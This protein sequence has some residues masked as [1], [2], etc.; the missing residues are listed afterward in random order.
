MIRQLHETT[1]APSDTFVPVSFGGEHHGDD[2]H[3]AGV[4]DVAVPLIASPGV[5][6][7]VNTA[8]N[9]DMVLD[10]F[11][12]TDPP[13]DLETT[14]IT[15]DPNGTNYTQ[16]PNHQDEWSA[17]SPDG[18]WVAWAA[19]PGDDFTRIRVG[20]IDD[21][22]SAVEPDVIG[23]SIEFESQSQPAWR[24]DGSALA[25]VSNGDLW[26]VEIDTSGESPTFDNMRLVYDYDDIDNTGLFVGHPTY[27]PDQHPDPEV[28]SYEIAFDANGDI[29]KIASDGTTGDEEQL[30]STG[31]A[32]NPSWS[33]TPGDDRIA[34]QRDAPSIILGPSAVLTSYVPPQPAG[35]ISPTVHGGVHFTVT[36]TADENDAQACL[37]EAG[38]SLREA[39]T[40]ANTAPNDTAPDQIDFS[41]SPAGPITIQPTSALGPLPAIIDPVIL[42]GFSQPGVFVNTEPPHVEIDGTSAGASANGLE[43]SA[44]SSLIQGFV[45]NRFGGAGIRLTGGG[46]NVVQ[47]NYIGTD[48]LGTSDLGNGTGIEIFN[49]AAN[50]VGGA[51]LIPDTLN[52]G[53]LNVVSGNVAGIYVGLGML[54][55]GNRIIGNYIGLDASGAGALGNSGAGIGISGPSNIIGSATAG[56]RNIISANGTGIHIGVN[57]E[58]SANDNVV[59][60]NY[61]GTDVSGTLD[62]G[63]TSAGVLVAGFSGQLIGGSG[64]GEGNLISG[65]N[66]LGVSIESGATITTVEGNRIG[67]SAAGDSAIANGTGLRILAANGNTV[68]GA[69]DAARN[70]ISGNAA[71]GVDLFA[72]NGNTISHN[73][74]GTD[75]TGTLALPNG[76]GVTILGTTGNDTTNNTISGNVVS[77]NTGDGIQISGLAATGQTIFDNRIGINSDG[78]SLGN[79]GRGVALISGAQSNM[80]GGIDPGEPN[81]IAF[82]GSDGVLVLDGPFNRVRGNSIHSNGT[83]P[84][85]DPPD[86]DLGIDLGGDGVTPNDELDRDSSSEDGIG[87][88]G[89]NFPIILSASQSGGSITVSG[90][91]DSEDFL[92][93]PTIDVYANDSCNPSGNGEGERY[94]GSTDIVPGLDSFGHGTWS[95][96]VA[97]SELGSEVTATA[98][99]N[100]QNTSEF[101]PCQFVTA[102]SATFTVNQV[103]DETD[104]DGC[105]V[106]HCTLREAIEG[107]NATP[108]GD[109]IN[110]D[111]PDTVDTPPHVITLLTALPDITDPVDIDGTTE[112]DYAGLPVIELDGSALDGAGDHGLHITADTI[113][114]IGLA[115]GGFGGA[116]IFIDGDGSNV[117]DNNV[118]QRNHIGVDATGTSPRGN[119]GDGIRIVESSGNDIGGTSEGGGNVIAGN[120]GNGVLVDPGGGSATDS[121][122]N[123]IAGNLIGID[124]GAEV[125]PNNGDGVRLEDV[126]LTDVGPFNVI[127]GNVG[128]GVQVFGTTQPNSVFG[129][130]IGTNDDGVDLGNGMAGVRV[131]N[132]NNAVIGAEDEGEGGLDFLANVIAGNDS[133]GVF[134]D[135]SF[136]T[137]VVSNVI[138]IVPTDSG[139]LFR[140]NAGDGIHVLDSSSTDIGGDNSEFQ[141]GNLIGKNT[142]SGIRLESAVGTDIRGNAIGT[143]VLGESVFGNL[144]AGIHVSTGVSAT[145]IGGTSPTEA[146]FIAFNGGDGILVEATSDE[147]TIQGNSIDQNGQLGIDLG[148][149]GVTPNDEAALDS[150]TGANGLQNFP[151]LTVSNFGTSVDGVLHSAASNPYTVE[152]FSSPACDASEFGEGDKS[153]GSVNV[154]TDPSGTATFALEIDPL[155]EGERVTATA[156]DSDGNTSEFSQCAEVFSAGIWTVKPDGTANQLLVEGG[157]QPSWGTGGRVA[158]VRDRNIWTIRADGAGERQLTDQGLDSK[159]SLGPILAFT[160]FLDNVDTSQDDVFLLTDQFQVVVHATFDEDSDPDHRKLDLL[161]KCTGSPTFDVAVA[162]N[163]VDSDATTASWVA[164]YDPSLTCPNGTLSVAVMDGRHR[165]VDAGEA[166]TDVTGDPAPVAAIYEPDADHEDT[167]L[168]GAGL[169]LH[170]SG[171]DSP[172]G[173]LTGAAVQWFVTV[174]GG[175][176]TEVDSTDCNSSRTHCDI[177]PPGGGLWPVGPL[178]VELRVTGSGG[179]MD[180]DFATI[181]VLKDS[182]NDGIPASADSLCNSDTNPQDAYLDRDGDGTLAGDDYAFFG[183]PCVGGTFGP[184]TLYVPSSGETVSMTVKIPG[185]DLRTVDRNSVVLR[186]MSGT[187]LIPPIP[188]TGWTVASKGASATATFNRQVVI[189]KL[190]DLGLV[191]G[192][193]YFT[194]TGTSLGWTFDATD[195]ADVKPAN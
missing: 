185:R 47:G 191:G 122:F 24:P 93:T 141:V 90:E 182:D 76:L 125:T 174:A 56:E 144:G 176:A 75:L 43:V 154:T 147:V 114:I 178:T 98:T 145:D 65:N 78:G 140:A 58:S 124:L 119:G 9:P 38:C 54:A 86:A 173:E 64:S 96:T 167:I 133:H 32:S 129:N 83:P 163:P 55:T 67:T 35:Q 27:S 193:V 2:D 33:Q 22:S 72:A 194:V 42:D 158:F 26:T 73:Y 44:G 188:S 49:S 84:V 30:T 108:T 66:A 135:D 184:D 109:V 180:S 113:G 150:D 101:S 186:F 71:A 18:Q 29:F 8:P 123:Q 85:P 127:G 59:Q 69:S 165:V 181:E 168:Q 41:V 89:M 25:F 177:D 80:V 17:V 94:L 126:Y 97:A 187:E 48:M 131:V 95:L 106:D 23:T 115:I 45:I 137:I 99:D 63:N 10:E 134:V 21:A 179:E 170:G 132:A 195:A 11:D 159:P 62:R 31:D 146:N 190:I 112:P 81:E 79:G 37:G 120:G 60:G 102:G 118:I 152:I 189:Q 142:G 14:I 172:V 74:I 128:N 164:N 121:S 7:F 6:Q 5:I 36:T 88:D 192:T 139:P 91:L 92:D 143:G 51:G 61:I 155:A 82:N 160:R 77:G 138:G 171:H 57:S 20:P 28:A 3:V 13:T 70:T 162:V 149:N 175:V 53:Q 117:S 151:S 166:L 116:G 52:A 16:D 111:I 161:Y 39:I 50:T 130:S 15:A 103:V 40:A 148:N 4:V 110:F 100:A 19:V 87:N 183:S 105:T 68:G 153:L 169:A 156:T 107:A 46:S 34:Y 1:G 12:P 157:G 104:V 136:G